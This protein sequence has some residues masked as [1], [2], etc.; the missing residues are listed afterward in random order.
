MGT[1]RTNEQRLRSLVDAL[2]EDVLTA[3]DEELLAEL[4]EDGGAAAL[5]AELAADIEA[6]KARLGRA[7]LHAARKAVSAEQRDSRKARQRFSPDEARR[8]LSRS[9]AGSSGASR[10]TLAA[11]KGQGVP[12]EDLDGL[13]E[14]AADLGI[15]L[16]ESEDSS[17]SR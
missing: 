13:I 15:N 2:V 1:K 8:R 6:A 7:K 4:A 12:D 10:L 11:R 14:D 16:S 3:S 9:V 17:D 5:K